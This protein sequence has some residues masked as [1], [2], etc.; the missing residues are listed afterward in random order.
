MRVEDLRYF[1]R[2]ADVLNYTRAAEEL[3]I[4]QPTLSLAIKR[5]E[6][7]WGV[8]LFARNR[9]VVELTEVGAD[10]LGC[11]NAALWKLERASML[12]KESTG[13]ENASINVGTIWATQGRYW[14][15][16]MI[17][18][19]SAHPLQPRI[20]IALGK[21][22]DLVAKLRAGK[23][24]VVFGSRT[25]ASDD[26]SHELVWSQS[27]AAGMN[28]EHP[29]AGCERVSLDDLRGY[30]VLTYREDAPAAPRI[31]ALC[32]GRGLDLRFEMDEIALASVVSANRDQV[33]LFCYSAMVDAFDGMV[34]RPIVEAPANFHDIYM[35]SRDEGR[36]PRAVHD[37]IDF[38]AAYEINVPEGERT[39]KSL[40]AAS[41]TF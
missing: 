40:A 39:F 17:D 1:Q 4:S 13:V 12:A 27:L 37:F 25:P 14:S 8:M 6:E 33:A 22:K 3:H 26:L 23:L 20:D 31:R 9:S 18:F 11:V 38:M 41:E 10:I 15:R 32:E 2:L 34:C 24:D 29:L 36:Q 16:A 7:E 5:L 19:S 35:I 28:R 21:S 30:P